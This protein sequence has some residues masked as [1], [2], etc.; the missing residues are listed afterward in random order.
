MK[1]GE[2][3][4]ADLPSPIGRRPVLL[5]SRGQAYAVRN[6]ITVAFITT[7]IRNIPVEVK[8]T[9]AD[10]MPK[11]CVVNLDLIN[12]I[13]KGTLVKCI[14]TLSTPKLAEVKKAVRFAL[15]L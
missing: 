1:R 7:T 11:D 9:P 8:L 15:E 2:V 14:C 3:W 5:L 6:A 13:P 4:W 12:T 10:G